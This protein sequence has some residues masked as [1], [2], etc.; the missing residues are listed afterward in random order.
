L[1]VAKF[2]C[3]CGQ[4][5]S[6]SGPIPNP[7]EWRCLSDTD[8]DAFTGLVNAEDIYQQSTMMYRC[9]ASGHLWVFWRGF[10]EPPAV[11]TPTALPESY[12]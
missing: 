5:L 7:D 6:T 4:A 11:Y 9:P 3:V 8:F 2:L 12:G 1:T 10:E